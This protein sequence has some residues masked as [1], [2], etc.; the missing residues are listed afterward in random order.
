MK[1]QTILKLIKDMI[2][3]DFGGKII[4]FISRVSMVSEANN[5]INY[6]NHSDMR[7]NKKQG[8]LLKTFK[9]KPIKENNNFLSLFSLENV[10]NR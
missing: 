10:I 1:K 8:C 9:V 2:K 6:V 5:S 7:I 4:N 3:R